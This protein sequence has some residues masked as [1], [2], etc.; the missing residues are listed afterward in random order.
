MENSMA[1]VGIAVLQSIYHQSQENWRWCNK[2]EGL[3]FA[4]NPKPGSCPA[5]ATCEHAS[6]GN[7][8]LLK[9][10]GGLLG[11]IDE[12]RGQENWRWCNKCEGLTF[13]G[14]PKPGS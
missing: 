7:Y 2:C 12:I 5:G 9:D 6:S 14:N 13:A 4:G 1:S 8:S 3:T 11:E 10:V